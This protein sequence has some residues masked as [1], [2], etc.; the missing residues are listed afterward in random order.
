QKAVVA[1]D[2]ANIPAKIAAAQAVATTNEDRYLIAHLQLQA[3][4]AAN[5]NDQIA[6]AVDALA[7][8]NLVDSATLANVYTGLGVNFYN[9]KHYDRAAADF[10]RAVALNPSNAEPLT[11]LAEAQ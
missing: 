9:T 2:I 1:K 5:D 11:L 6:V 8:S 10:Q 3:G 4:L 7:A